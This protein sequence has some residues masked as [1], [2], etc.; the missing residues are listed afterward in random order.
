MAWEWENSEKIIHTPR[1]ICRDTV[2]FDFKKPREKKELLQSNAALAFLR[3]NK[4]MEKCARWNWPGDGR[5]FLIPV[6]MLQYMPETSMFR[7]VIA[8]IS[9]IYREQ[10]YPNNC[11][12]TTSYRQ[13]AD[14]LGLSWHGGLSREI[15]SLL[16]FAKY[17]TIE[18]MK[19][20][21]ELNKDG[22][23][24]N[25]EFRT[26]GFVAEWG[27]ED[28]TNGV[29]IPENKAKV[30][31]DLTKTYADMI[32]NLVPAP[33][34]VEA[35]IQARTAPRR[36]ISPAKNMIYRLAARVPQQKIT[37]STDT[38]RN[39]LGISSKTRSDK[40]LKTIDSVFQT[41]YPVMVRD[42]DLTKDKVTVLLAGKLMGGKT[43]VNWEVKRT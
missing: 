12:I 1:Q 20:V 40:A 29:K 33:V 41:L 15:S 11:L 31:I 7:D 19:I 21:T 23:I 43:D 5:V 39:I 6:D 37:Y 34:P 8:C 42:F 4:K 26:F 9:Q 25:S 3:N 24:K 16:T 13:I 30:L 10:G 22:T 2:Y 32:K 18:N 28:I 27:R 36:L 17:F 14:S 35:L 38:L